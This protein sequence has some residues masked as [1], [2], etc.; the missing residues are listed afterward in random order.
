MIS[1]DYIAYS[2]SHSAD[3]LFAR[4]DMPFGASDSF[5]T[6]C[7]MNFFW[8]IAWLAIQSLSHAEG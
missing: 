6:W 1:I 3:H 8:V 5:L 2:A 7:C 4:F